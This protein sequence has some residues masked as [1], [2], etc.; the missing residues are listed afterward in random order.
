MTPFER[1]WFNYEFYVPWKTEQARKQTK[2]V[3]NC[4]YNQLMAFVESLREEVQLSRLH[5]LN[6][7][8]LTMENEKLKVRVRELETLLRKRT[9]PLKKQRECDSRKNI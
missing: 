5:K 8:N 2:A 9:L 3:A 6:A 7:E 4:A 1:F